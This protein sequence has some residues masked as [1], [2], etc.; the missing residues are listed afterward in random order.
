MIDLERLFSFLAWNVSGGLIFN[1]DLS[2]RGAI[3]I[4]IT[5]RTRKTSVRGV[6]FISVNTSP[7]PPIA[8][9]QVP[10][11]R[12]IGCVCALF[13]GDEAEEQELEELEVIVEALDRIRVP[14]VEDNGEDGDDQTVTGCDKS[15]GNA[16]HDC[17]GATT[18][19]A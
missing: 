16:Q 1:S 4:M 7:A 3:K 18:G 6:I 17:L 19:G 5:R 14:V 13:A 10:L 11:A 15:F 9:D 8:I 12:S 2:M